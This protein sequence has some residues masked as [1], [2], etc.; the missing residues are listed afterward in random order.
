M[1]AGVQVRLLQGSLSL[2]ECLDARQLVQLEHQRLGYRR[3]RWRADGAQGELLLQLLGVLGI[4]AQ[5]HPR[6]HAGGVHR[7]IDTFDASGQRHLGVL[8]ADRKVAKRM[9]GLT[10][11][12]DIGQCLAPAIEELHRVIAI[13]DFRYRDLRA[14]ALVQG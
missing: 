8:Q 4:G 1:H 10:A 11:L 12:I 3:K 9:I 5:L 14:T 2:V 6:Q 13:D 7:Q